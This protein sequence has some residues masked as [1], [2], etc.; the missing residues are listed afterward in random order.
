MRASIRS[1]ASV[2]AFCSALALP[3]PAS[4]VPA[5]LHEEDR[6]HIPAAYAHASHVCLK[7][8]HLLVLAARGYDAENDAWAL[9]HYRKQT[10]TWQFI[11]EVVVDP[12]DSFQDT[13]SYE[14]L[15]CNDQLAAMSTPAGSSYAVELVGSRW[16]ATPVA[17]SASGTAVFGGTAAFSTNTPAPVTI[18]FIA[19][20][21]SGTWGEPSLA[22]GNPGFAGIEDFSGP[23]SFSFAGNQIAAASGNYLAGGRH[24]PLVDD[25]EV[26]DLVSGQ[27]QLT[28]L[29]DRQY[30]S[31]AIGDEVALAMQ[32][33]TVPGEVAAY[34][35][36]SATGDWTVKLSLTS[37]E[38]FDGIQQVRFMN[39]RAFALAAG[40]VVMFERQTDRLY[41]HRATIDLADATEDEF[42]LQSYDVDGNRLAAVGGDGSTIYLFTISTPLPEPTVFQETFEGASPSEWEPWGKTDWRVVGAGP[43]HAY[44]QRNIEGNARTILQTLEGADQAIQA[45]LRILSVD[46]PTPWAGLMVRYTDSNNFYYLLV[47][48]ASIQIR[49]NIDGAFEPIA[50]V[51]FALTLG[52][53]YRFRLEAIGTRIRAFL[54]GELVA[55]AVDDAHPRGKVGLAMWRT[56]SEYDNVFASSSPQR[57]LFADPFPQPCCGGFRERPWTAIPADRWTVVPSGTEFVY[58]QASTSGVAYAINGGPTADQIVSA[59][60][61]PRAFNA[62]SEGFAG[63]V[64]RHAD[65]S[66]YYYGVLSDDGRISLRKVVD[67]VVTILDEASFPVTANVAHTV[68]L[69]AIG[70]SIRMYVGRWLYLEAE[71]GAL[72][73]GNYGLITNNAAADFD[74]VKAIRP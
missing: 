73:T 36:R 28:T 18:V 53:T 42:W 41:R 40:A 46:G 33:W 31:A 24:G 72:P 3:S 7:G 6:V 12:Y 58:R 9:L 45:D 69:E 50:R 64:A 47:N 60:V 26:F 68:R 51:P 2:T 43:S 62:D 59:A 65:E 1:L 35:S 23:Q 48:A 54:N 21:A 27:W 17:G 55:E 13:W 61:R 37:A 25:T 52:H 49:R 8:D 10:G 19:K 16:Q 4:E 57:E 74:N 71:D 39:D 15:A 29:P 11:E 70:S 63:V 38:R 66:N 30:D 5:L 34:Y 22:I 14:D 67:G 56:V 20:D 44:R 32:S